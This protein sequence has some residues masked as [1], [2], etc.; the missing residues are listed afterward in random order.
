MNQ[1][2]ASASS[3][4]SLTAASGRPI[5]QQDLPEYAAKGVPHQN[6]DT[7]LARSPLLEILFDDSGLQAAASLA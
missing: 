2:A 5:G 1:T 6:L 7:W 4:S 3:P